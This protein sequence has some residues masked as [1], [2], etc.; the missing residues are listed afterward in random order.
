M[1]H[2]IPIDTDWYE[3][4]AMGVRVL[5][6]PTVE[7]FEDA[8]WLFKQVH[9]MSAF[10]IADLYNWGI[11][12]PGE[13]DYAQALHDTGYSYGYLTNISWVARS[14]P[15]SRRREGLSFSHHQAVAS[16]EPE[17]QDVW[18]NHAEQKGM[19]RSELR[20]AIAAAKTPDLLPALTDKDNEVEQMIILPTVSLVE[21]VIEY[22]S[23]VRAKEHDK[24][25][26]TFEKMAKL[27]EDFYE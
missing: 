27:I 2:I 24:A 1:S 7:E 5:R 17:F 20:D 10:A 25:N 23:Y 15:L 8:I 16:L 6:V 9:T 19:N 18:L 26:D 3:L 12:D 14:I 4:T 11:A 22:V 13:T 21:V